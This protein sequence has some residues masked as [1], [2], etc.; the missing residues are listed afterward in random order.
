MNITKEK[1]EALLIQ[2]DIEG[3]IA[4]GAPKDE[5]SDEAFIIFETLSNY[6][7]ADLD[8]NDVALIISN[9]WKNKFNLDNEEIEK[10]RSEIDSVSKDTFEF[11]N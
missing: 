6:K 1:I 9:V 10:R 8:Y 5:Y 11:F 2:Y 7:S 3:L 4:L